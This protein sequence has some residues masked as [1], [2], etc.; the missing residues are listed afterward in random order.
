[1]L[2]QSIDTINHK[3]RRFGRSSNN[4]LT[5]LDYDDDLVLVAEQITNAQELLVSLENAAIKFGLVLNSKKR[6][7]MPINQDLIHPPIFALNGSAIKEVNG[8]K[9]LG[10]Q[11]EIRHFKIN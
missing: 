7:N 10:S 4:H 1:M 11:M 6:E 3:G 2:R 5:D 8:F 9:Y